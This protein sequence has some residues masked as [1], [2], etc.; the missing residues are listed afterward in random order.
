MSVERR[1]HVALVGF[2]RPPHNFFDAELVR[3]ICDAMEGAQGDGSSRVVVLWSEGRNFCAGANIRTGAVGAPGTAYGIADVTR[4]PL[5]LYRQGIRLFRCELPVVAAV[6]GAAV[7]GGLGLALAADFRMATPR[8]RF[9]CNFAG[10]GFH[11]GFGLTVTLPAV[12]GQQR[13]WRLLYTGGQLRGTEALEA[14]LCDGIVPS[15]RLLDA[16]IELAQSMAAAGPLAVRSIRRTMRDGLA[17]RV[18]Q[19]MVAESRAQ[20]ALADTADFAEGVRAAA[21]RRPANWVGR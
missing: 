14:G 1:G 15:E 5:D 21:E 20:A 18:W 6:Q 8:T 10:I 3:G 13:A 12:V 17:D 2:H 4:A 9:H 16:S 11:H 19:A 7:G